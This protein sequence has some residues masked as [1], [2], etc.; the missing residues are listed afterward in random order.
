MRHLLLFITVLLISSA[1]AQETKWE[2]GGELGLNLSTMSG[3]YGNVDRVED[4]G[5]KHGWIA[6]PNVG[7]AAAYRATTLVAIVA[8]LYMIKSGLVYRNSFTSAGEEYSWSQRERYTTLRIPIM[9]RFMWGQTWQFYAL[10]GLY[11][12]KRLC[13][14]EVYKDSYSDE[15]SIHKLRFK[16]DPDYS[17]QEDDVY[18]LDTKYHRRLNL[19]IQAGGGIRRAIGQGF[20]A[21]TVLYGMGFFDFFKWE[22]KDDKPEGYKPFNDRNISFNLGY[23]RPIGK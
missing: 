16:N 5:T 12:S 15:K 23:T 21:F 18:Y 4:D 1:Y 17:S 8:G 14:R 10:A 13:G 11:V 9:A 6:T 19:G 20:I 22:N 2:I 3:N 7:F